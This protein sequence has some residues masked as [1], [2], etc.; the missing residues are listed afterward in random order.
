MVYINLSKKNLS[1]KLILQLSKWIKLP[2]NR[3]KPKRFEVGSFS[4]DCEI[5][6]TSILSEHESQTDL[7]NASSKNPIS[8]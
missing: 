1:F 4:K 5:A 6:K 3:W 2:S 7:N 8:D